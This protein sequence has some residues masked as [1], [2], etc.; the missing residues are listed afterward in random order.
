M[1]SSLHI[2]SLAVVLACCSA[3]TRD[4]AQPPAD[5]PSGVSEAGAGAAIADPSA[6]VPEAAADQVS[7][8]DADFALLVDWMT[9][10][11]SSAAQAAGDPE[12]LDI[13]LFMTRIWADR[14]DGAWLYVEQASASALARP[15]RQ[16]VYRVTTS[17]D[18]SFRSEVFE[19]PGDPLAFAGSWRDPSKFASLDPGTLPAREGC[20]IVLR[21][22]GDGF[23]GSTQ[24]NSCPSSL[25]GATYATSTVRI[26]SRGMATWDRGFDA[27]GAQVWGA[28]KGAYEFARVDPETAAT[29][30]AR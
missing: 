9:G 14:D 4:A 11:F 29:P 24:G 23:N 27:S 30:G 5:P 16:R 21:R 25:R 13:R 20:A 8:R 10:A 2:G 1:T 15:Y 22:D 6:A 7:T 18:G 17:D 19:L 28:T 12:F 26:S 3:C